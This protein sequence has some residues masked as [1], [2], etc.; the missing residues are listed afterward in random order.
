MIDRNGPANGA[1]LGGACKGEWRVVGGVWAETEFWSGLTGVELA[2]DSRG[3]VG[4]EL[5]GR[6]A[7]EGSGGRLLRP[8]EG[9]EF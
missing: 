6:W 8:L 5:G 1:V 9:F 4:P 7:G 2:R 3:W